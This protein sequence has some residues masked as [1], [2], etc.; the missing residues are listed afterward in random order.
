LHQCFGHAFAG[1]R[2]T[3]TGAA[4]VR[5][6]ILGHGIKPEMLFVS[7]PALNLFYK[8]YEK[9]GTI[10]EFCFAIHNKFSFMTQILDIGQ[11]VT[12]SGKSG[13]LYDGRIYNKSS[14]DSLSG[15]A[16]ACLT[17]STFHDHHW[18]HKMNSVL[19]DFK[20]RDDISHL[21]L[22]SQHPYQSGAMDTVDDLIRRYIHQDAH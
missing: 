8:R 2:K 9:P 19:E 10:Q 18:T 4:F 17:N 5:K 15:H 11:A 14:D 12:L 13:A 21:I 22:I 20:K 3:F 1:L 6:Q 7:P 16:I